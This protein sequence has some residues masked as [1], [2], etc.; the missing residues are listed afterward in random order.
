[1]FVIVFTFSKIKQKNGIA[2]K[3]GNKMPKKLALFFNCLFFNA[4]C[5]LI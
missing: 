3:I 1:V 5:V 2:K 4:L